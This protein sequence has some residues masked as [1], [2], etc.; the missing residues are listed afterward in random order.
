MADEQP[1][2][3]DLE[4]ARARGVEDSHR[5]AEHAPDHPLER[6]AWA[7]GFGQLN[8]LQAAVE[9]A[10]TRGFTWKQIAET[11][12]E[13][14]QTTATKYGGGYKRQREYRE[15]RNSDS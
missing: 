14:W 5:T 11:L 10:R 7:Q 3:A 9:A 2:P 6:V 12:G 8:Q 13:R 1:T 4:A 15:R